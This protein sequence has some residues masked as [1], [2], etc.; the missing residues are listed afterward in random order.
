MNNTKP[1]SLQNAQFSKV[2][3]LICAIKIRET[4]L[5]S[6]K[7]PL[8][9]SQG[10]ETAKKEHKFLTQTMNNITTNYKANSLQSGHILKIAY[11]GHSSHNKIWETALYSLEGSI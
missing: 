6:L 7:G 2:S 1:N 5:Y 11:S 3:V 9:S 8:E 10:K 4:A